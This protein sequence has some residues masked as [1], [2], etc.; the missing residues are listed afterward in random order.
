V[1][2]APGVSRTV[3][4]RP[5]AATDAALYPPPWAVRIPAWAW[6]VL[7]AS[8]YWLLHRSAYLL[9][10][11]PGGLGIVWPPA[12][13]VLYALLVAPRRMWAA[14]LGAALAVGATVSIG[15][16]R[17]PAVALAYVAANLAQ[18]LAARWLVV[19]IG[20][21]P[22]IRTLRGALAMILAP[23]AAVVAVSVLSNVLLLTRGPGIGDER[24]WVFWA[25]S[26]LGILFTT[27]LLVEW[28]TPRRPR[29]EPGRPLLAAAAIAAAF[30]VAIAL[31][32]S[33]RI[34]VDEVVLLPPLV[35]AAFRFGPRG[36][37]VGLVAAATAVFASAAAGTG[38]IG[39]AASLH[40]AGGSTLSLQLFLALG[41]AS[42]LVI[43]AVEEERRAAQE[44]RL[45]LER[46][47]DHTPDP[48]GV[49]EEDGSIVWVN[50]AMARE[51]AVPRDMLVGARVWE[52][53]PG[54]SREAWRE[55][56]QRVAAGAP[57]V[58]EELPASAG[59]RRT[60]W[61]ISAALVRLDGRRVMVSVLHDLSDRRRAEDASRLAS[62]G[63]LAAGVAHEINNPLAYVVANIAHVRDR[64]GALVRDAPPEVV[65]SDVLDPL[66][67]AEDGARRVR[68]IVRQLR[69]FAHPEEQV[70]HLQPARALHA[71]LAMAQHEIRH[72]ARL[73]EDV[74]PTPPVMGNEN[75]LVQVFVNLLV[76]AAQA[77]PE[78]NAAAHEVRVSLRP[79]GDEVVAQIADT[80]AG[81]S[82]ET[83]ARVF[84][85]FFTTKGPGSGVGLGLAISHSI[86]TG[87]GGR[88]EVESEPGRGSLFRVILPVARVAPP[89]A[90]P[91]PA[92]GAPAPPRPHV[93]VVDDEPLVSRA[94]ARMLEADADVVIAER[95][96]DAL[97][98]VRA[99]ERF[100]LV[101]CDLMM[102]DLSGME[103]HAALQA[104]D[105]AIADRMVFVTGGAFTQAASE[106]LERVPN[107][108]LEKPIDRAALR[109]VVRRIG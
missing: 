41:A 96:R 31:L 69:A 44:R 54:S 26:T 81:M 33:R 50:E 97:E 83:R 20:G 24:F 98:R 10:D 79:R 36:A 45:L 73:L 59:G 65:R 88:I 107:A 51:L 106:F 62:L 11:H 78:G 18:A 52:V 12:G 4:G 5:G 101:L 82:A 39:P 27:P 46:A 80:G 9:A 67:E 99:G 17:A 34:M 108:R 100:D 32:R 2:P 23:A 47:F 71:A 30:V 40:A 38:H 89:A 29:S 70:G 14:L 109:E 37:T 91:A 66:A 25:G 104:I 49:F 68:D 55:R 64:I 16:G 42:I 90:A 103:L 102:P 95:A 84:E 19:R 58:V 94:L 63:T 53:T 13:L 56:W 74:A 7:F 22:T 92:P 1:L 28:T 60:P 6:L 21:R 86:V 48:A 85:P 76:N 8:A 93:L 43:A 75:R 57:A 77:I 72:R 15:Y 35:W 3:V 105:P 87:L 61:E